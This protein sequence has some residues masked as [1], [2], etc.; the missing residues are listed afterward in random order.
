MA[1]LM[2]KW[3]RVFWLSVMCLLLVVG[4][5]NVLSAHA[6]YSPVY[7]GSYGSE[8]TTAQKGFY[9]ALKKQYYDE[10]SKM[11]NG[12]TNDFTYTLSTPIT[13]IATISMDMLYMMKTIK[14][15]V[16]N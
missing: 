8:L 7:N 14:R 3:Q 1:K 15:H 4:G 9:N 12:N 5:V 11:P 13:F 2:K 16:R 6:A 10:G